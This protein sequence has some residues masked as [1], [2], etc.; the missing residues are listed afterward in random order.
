MRL[1]PEIN[2]LA[3]AHYLQAL[4]FQRKATQIVA[5]LGGKTPHIQ[6]LTVGGVANAI[7]L[8][9]LATLNT[10]RLFMI[11]SLIDEV[12]PFV[13]QVYFPDVCAI[14]GAY[15][16]W[17]AYGGG[18]KN[19]LAVPELPRDNRAS[20]FDLPGGVLLNGGTSVTTF[21]TAADQSFRNAVTEDL[22]HA[23]VPRQ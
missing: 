22:A 18:V 15:P 10:D 20:S 17:F 11:K 3:F 12:V 16:D 4:D 14:A 19:Y 2:L 21:T 13:H 8:D 23:W 7:N 6:N 9:S 5:V 1:S